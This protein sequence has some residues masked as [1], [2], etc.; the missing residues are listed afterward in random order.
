MKKIHLNF[1][2]EESNFYD[3]PIPDL[4][5]NVQNKERSGFKMTKHIIYLTL[6]LSSWKGCGSASRRPTDKP[7][8]LKLVV[9]PSN[10][11]L[12]FANNPF[13]G[14]PLILILLRR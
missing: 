14:A 4:E 1:R 8:P 2:F 13:T 6:L 10:P 5:H 12:P 11:T 3:V 9:Q 7:P